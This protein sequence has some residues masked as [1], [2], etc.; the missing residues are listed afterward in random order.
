[1]STI[2]A[3]L[4]PAIDSAERG[5]VPDTLVRWGIRRLCRSMLDRSLHPSEVEN[6][7]AEMRASDV[8]LVPDLAN[9]QHYEVPPQ[10]FA[11]VLGRH[12][13]YSCCYW[14]RE[15][16]GLDE[17]EAAALAITAKRAALA[18]GQDI[19]ELGCGWGSLTLWM[20]ERY[21]E[22]RITAVSN[23]EPQA[24]FIRGRAEER[25]LGNVRFVTADMNEFEA[26]G[27]F[28]RVVS[29][30]MFEHMR[31]WEELLRRV[32]RWLRPDGRLFVHVF[33]HLSRP[34]LYGS[35]DWMGRHFFSGGIMPS[36]DLLARFDR[37]LRV[38][39]TW[40]WSGEHYR[41][42]AEAWLVR[43]DANREHLL[44]ILARDRG[45]EG[46]ERWLNRWRLFFL[47]CAELFG[48]SGGQEWGVSHYLLEPVRSGG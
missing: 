39:E 18:D 3:M 46:A 38:V 22:A 17:A 30:E 27:P 47:S 25:G 21:P 28:D 29:V 40:D 44:P 45:E 34:Y 41:D 42:T 31:N 4:N 48:Y 43:L 32:A 12:L 24:R 33:R 1:M 19:L 5:R 10:F 9:E 37:D 36:R 23:S 14:T 2:A 20:A 6:L 15:T 26:D 16:Q 7:V 8:A 35:D 11:A 13:K